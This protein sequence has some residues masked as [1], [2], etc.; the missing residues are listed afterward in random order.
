MLL[1]AS[2]VGFSSTSRLIF[3]WATSEW[4]VCWYIYAYIPVVNTEYFYSTVLDILITLDKIACFKTNVRSMIKLSSYKISAIAAALTL[5]VNFPFFFF[6][7]PIARTFVINSNE[8][9]TFWLQT[10]TAFAQSGV[11][12]VLSFTILA[13]RDV[14]TML[15]VIVLSIISAWC[16]KEYLDKRSKLVSK[17]RVGVAPTNDR[18]ATSTAATVATTSIGKP[19]GRAETDASS[20]TRQNEE[21]E[22]RAVKKLTIMVLMIC[23]LSVLEHLNVLLGITYSYLSAYPFFSPI[24]SRIHQ[25][26]SNWSLFFKQWINFP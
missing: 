26:L 23:L 19:S 2:T 1:V 17:K 5:A 25:S 6:F 15:L 16:L 9:V 11:G 8:T 21:K 10:T 4:A 12:T 14:V 24:I 3:P 20:S 18:T 13:I 22:T 7:R